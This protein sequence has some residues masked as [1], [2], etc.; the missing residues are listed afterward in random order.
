MWYI[1]HGTSVT[2]GPLLCSRANIVHFA[3]SFQVSS[4]DTLF[5]REDLETYLASL[6][7]ARLIMAAAKGTLLVSMSHEYS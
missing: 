1:F 3:T 5:D 2:E 7:E 6:S 4:L